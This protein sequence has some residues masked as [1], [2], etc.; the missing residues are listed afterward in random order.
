MEAKETLE[1]ALSD[2]EGAIVTVSHDR[3]FLDQIVNQI[4]EL[5]AG[6]DTKY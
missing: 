6:I 5:Q 1:D 3:W 2:N 4:W